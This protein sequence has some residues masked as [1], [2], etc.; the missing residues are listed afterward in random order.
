MKKNIISKGNILL[1]LLAFVFL[2]NFVINLTIYIFDKEIHNLVMFIIYGVG[3][4]VA[5]ICLFID[6]TSDKKYSIAFKDIYYHYG[7][8]I[9]ETSKLL[10]T[11]QIKKRKFKKLSTNGLIEYRL[12]DNEYAYQKIG[13]IKLIFKPFCKIISFNILQDAPT[14]IIDTLFSS[15]YISYINLPN[16]ISLS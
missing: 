13:L 5:T 14:A 16:S 3:F 6:F 9:I 15:L 7:E 12:I 2:L 11:K 10:E 8:N 4:I 1:F